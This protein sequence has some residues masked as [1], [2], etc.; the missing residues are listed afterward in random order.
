MIKRF[1]IIFMPMLIIFIS[2]FT[3]F[4]NVELDDHRTLMKE[5][6]SN[7]LSHILSAVKSEFR[8]IIS[9]LLFLS[10]QYELGEAFNANKTINWEGIASGYLSFSTEKRIYDQIRFIDETGMEIIRINYNYGNPTIV[11]REQLQFKGDRY[12][13]EDTFVLAQGEIFVSPMDLNIER[14]EIE[15]PL[16][17]MIRFAT[18]VFSLDGYKRGIII[19]N[20]LAENITHH[21]EI[22]PNGRDQIMLVNA[23]GFWLQSPKPEDEWG[24]MYPDKKERIFGNDLPEVWLT[25]ATDESGQFLNDDGLFAFTTIYPLLEGQKSSTGSVTA[26]EP[27]TQQLESEEYYWKLL[28][29]IPSSVLNAQANSLLTRFILIFAPIIVVVAG[30]SW[31]IAYAMVKR[32]RATEETQIANREL[33]IVNKELESFSYSVSHDLRAPLR[34]MDGFSKILLENYSDKLDEQGKDYLQR[35]RS[36]TQ[37]MGRLIDDILSLSRVIRNEMKH[38]LVDLSSLVESITTELQKSQPERQIEFITAPGVTANGDAGL[39]RILLENLLG[40]AWKY[41]GKHPK[42]IIEFGVTQVGSEEAFF[43]R[44]DGAGFDMAH[45]DKLFGMFQRLH[46]DDEFPGTGI[47]LATVQR[48]VHRHS[49]QVWAEGEVEKGA[50][51]YFTLG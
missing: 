32:I 28:S 24:F 9:D 26:F 46:S 48:I 51:F 12:Y 19:L 38:E 8:L 37:R 17:P 33:A 31:L 3:I 14:G 23:D 25:I 16:K 5:E 41:T 15:Q 42:A 4:Y 27:S 34:S 36:A 44:D 10:E 7:E 47:G 43:I 1:L 40:N 11:P 13:F 30:G 49:G 29:Y 22:T 39:L 2:I 35:V 6:A 45:T 18:P 50:T 21:F 20:Y